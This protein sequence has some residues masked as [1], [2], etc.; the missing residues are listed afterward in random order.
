MQTLLS[1]EII[2]LFKQALT[3]KRFIDNDNDK[4][5]KI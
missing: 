1:A 5:I 2:N 3:N 4:I